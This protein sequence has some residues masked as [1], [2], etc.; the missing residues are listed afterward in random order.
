MYNDYVFPGG[1]EKDDIILDYEECINYED[2]LGLYLDLAARLSNA[3][4]D[5]DKAG[6]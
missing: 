5:M 2:K 4:E 1:N 3:N 6:D